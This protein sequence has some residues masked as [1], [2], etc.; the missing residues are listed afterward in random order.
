M[1]DWLHE[2]KYKDK[3][4]PGVFLN[5][6]KESLMRSSSGRESL[7]KIPADDYHAFIARDLSSFANVPRRQ[8]NRHDNRDIPVELVVL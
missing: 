2:N 4:T 7:L 6:S 3:T 5:S 8:H 1:A